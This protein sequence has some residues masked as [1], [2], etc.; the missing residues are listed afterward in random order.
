MIESEVILY[1]PKCA[2]SKIV[3]TINSSEPGCYHCLDCKQ[4]LFESVEY[5]YITAFK[6]LQAENQELKRKLDLA[7]EALGFYG[8][9]VNWLNTVAS[10]FHCE[11]AKICAADLSNGVLEY[12]CEVG[13]KRA[14]KTLREIGEER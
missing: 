12:D 11:N 14:R 4:E 10:G 5:S 1:C 13:G 6:K 8:D 9:S 7:V 2:S 3:K